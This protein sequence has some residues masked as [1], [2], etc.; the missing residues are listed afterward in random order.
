MRFK[1]LVVVVEAVHSEE[2][3]RDGRCRPAIRKGES[4]GEKGESLRLPAE[5]A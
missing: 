2:T 5:D 1:Y 4:W 3:Q